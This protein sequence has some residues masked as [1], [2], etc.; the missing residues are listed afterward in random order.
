MQGIVNTEPEIR[1]AA[2]V[3]RIGE[4]D[5]RALIDFRIG[6]VGTGILALLFCA[7]G[8]AAIPFR[9]TPPYPDYS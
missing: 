7:L 3:Y 9:D 5:R 4:H 1:A 8:A 2:V 6:Y